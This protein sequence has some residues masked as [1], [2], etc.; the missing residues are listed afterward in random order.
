MSVWQVSLDLDPIS[1][2]SDL[3]HIFMIRSVTGY[4]WYAD[5]LEGVHVSLAGVT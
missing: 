3:R 2:S 4:I 5:T 1:R